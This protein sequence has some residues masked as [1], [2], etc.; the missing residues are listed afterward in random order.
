MEEL[1][2]PLELENVED[3]VEKSPAKKQ[4]LQVVVRRLF[5]FFFFSLFFVVVI[6]PATVV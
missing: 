6:L 4:K 5:F 3:N 2:Q 1:E